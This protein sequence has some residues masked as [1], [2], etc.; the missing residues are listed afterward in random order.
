[1]ENHFGRNVWVHRKGATSAREGQMGIIPGSMGTSSYIVRGKGNPESFHSCSHGAG[2]CIGRKQAS[3]TLKVEDCD[4]A[5]E[6]I[7]YGRW[8]TDRKGNVDLGEAPQA[9]KDI[10]VVM[11]SQ[12]DLVDIVTQLRP[13]AVIKG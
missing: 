13:L 8:G 5:M 4:K 3:R 2:R 11:E 6:G 10:D 1:M 7:V 12:K 9:Y